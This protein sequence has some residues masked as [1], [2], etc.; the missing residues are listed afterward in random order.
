MHLSS[1]RTTGYQFFYLRNGAALTDTDIPFVRIIFQS[2][3]MIGKDI[4]NNKYLRD[5]RRELD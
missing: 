1:F 2:F 4:R 3:W 5:R